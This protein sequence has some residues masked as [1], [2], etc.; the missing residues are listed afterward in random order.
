MLLKVRQW[1]ADRGAELLAPGRLTRGASVSDL[2]V[3]GRAVQRPGLSPPAACPLCA[4]WLGPAG[5]SGLEGRASGA[6]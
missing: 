1:Q 5:R 2:S 4:C 3:R 6:G